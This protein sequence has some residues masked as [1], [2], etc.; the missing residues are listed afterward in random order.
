MQDPSYGKPLENYIDFEQYLTDK[1]LD[2]HFRKTTK[3]DALSFL[4]EYNKEYGSIERPY[5]LNFTL[6]KDFTLK[7]IVEDIFTFRCSCPFM[8][9]SCY[10]M[11]YLFIQDLLRHM[12]E[13][14]IDDITKRSDDY[15]VITD[16]GFIVFNL[17]GFSIKYYYSRK[18]G[19][20]ILKQCKIKKL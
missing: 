8:Y 2:F 14:H 10:S 4:H 1:V 5:G 3:E 15:L 18:N 16:H 13:Y 17:L 7:E 9:C 19:I 20:S 11:F 12:E 6:A